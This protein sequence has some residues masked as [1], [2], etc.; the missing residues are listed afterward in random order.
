MTIGII[1]GKAIRLEA[2]SF[3]DRLKEWRPWKEQ[4]YRILDRDGR[5]VWHEEEAIKRLL[6][7]AFADCEA[8]IFL[9]GSRASGEC[10]ERSDYDV[11][12]W[13][14]CPLSAC[15]LARLREQL[16]ELPIP[17]RIELV[18]FQNVPEEFA[19][20]VLT[21]RVVKEWKR[22]FKNSIFI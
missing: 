1:P 20:M 22:R 17:A 5:T 9:F 15:R 12:Y 14:D 2:Q 21:T 13:A 8:D 6:L 16:E 11:G 7:E 3:S 18:D 4:G 10:R 19:R